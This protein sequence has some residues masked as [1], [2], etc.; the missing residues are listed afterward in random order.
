MACRKCYISNLFHKPFFHLINLFKFER[1]LGF[2]PLLH[3][4][5]Y[6]D[7]LRQ[8][9]ANGEALLAKYRSNIPGSDPTISKTEHFTASGIRLKVYVPPN[10]KVNSPLV[11]YIHGGGFVI[12]SADEDDRFVER[13]STDTGYIFVSVDYRLA[14]QHKY[15]ASLNDCVEGAKWCVENAESLGANH[16]RGI[17]IMG[18]SAGGCLA[19]A[20][21]LTLIDEGRGSDVLG[22]VPCQPLTMHPDAVPGGFRDRYT[23]YDENAE[24]TVNTKKCMYAIFGESQSLLAMNGGA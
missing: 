15:P 9:D 23:A 24:R 8:D 1:E 3:G 11:Y 5:T 13:H 10:V 19:F 17:V 16:A 20:T 14:P 12:G 7:I 4:P 22:I 18:K 2:R 6:Q 21:A